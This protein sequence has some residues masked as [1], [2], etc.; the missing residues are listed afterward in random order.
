MLKSWIKAICFTALALAIVPSGALTDSAESRAAKIVDGFSVD[1]V[2][3][4]MTQINI[5][6]LLNS[7]GGLDE[8]KVRQFAKLHVGSYLGSPQ[9]N[10]PIG[11]NYS[12]SVDEWRKMIT[13][14]QDIHKEEG[15]G[16]PIIYGID[17]V[18]GANFILNTTIFGHQINGGASFN[19]DLVRKMGEITG[20]DTAAAGISW[21][22]GPILEL[23]QNPLWPRTYETFGE[24]PYLVS[25]MGSNVIKGIQA[26]KDVAACMKHFVGYSKTPTGHDRDGV[27]LSDFDLLNYFMPPFIAATQA[28]VKSA[29]ENYISINGVPVVA[30][31]K[32]LRDLLRRDLGFEG[33][34]VTD[35]AEIYNLN[36]FHRVAKSLS[37]AVRMSL[38]QTSIDMSMVAMDSNFITYA[39]DMLK[40]FPE[41]YDRL[42]ES[43][44]RI[45]K[46]KI[47]LGLY[48]TPVPGAKY[49]KDVGS[50]AHR[51]VALDLARESIVLLKN[52]DNTLPL[53]TSDTV[54]LTGHSADDRGNLCG[55]WSLRWPGYS[56]NSMF[57]N[58]I[59]VKDGFQKLASISSVSY[60]N[61]LTVNGTYTA[62]DLAKAKEL[63]SKAK[64]TV[65][66]IGEATYAEKSG[67]LDD[68]ALPI[69]Q[70]N[71][72]KELASTGTKVIVVL[73]GGRPRLLSGLPSNVHAVINALLPGELGGQAI[74]EIIYG[75]VNPSGRL[76]IT[77]PK[78]PANIMIPYNRRVTTL[79]ADQTPCKMEWDF[80]TGLSY[81]TFSYS[82]VKLSKT[83][84]SGKNDKVKASVTVTN[85]GKVKGKETVMLFLIQPFR[86]ISVPEAKQLKKFEKIELAPGKSKTV[87]FELNYKDWSVFDPQIGKGF[88][89]SA[90]DGDFVV[91]I[92]PETDCDVYNSAGITNPLCAKFTLESSW[93]PFRL[94]APEQTGISIVSESD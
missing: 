75:K 85:T 50:S 82:A 38:T 2:L 74:A 58:G 42:K 71:Y 49:V 36:S 30:S 20:R 83:K 93:V 43:A 10:G 54:F 18:H 33:F 27:T 39:K 19:P 25:V 8:D 45:I 15:N 32:I 66:V 57:P 13:R 92:K 5:A 47:E 55:G 60:F 77:Y 87:E 62:D 76:P 73:V 61:G 53:S 41:Y 4:Q 1:E 51:D 80:G 72:V 6:V 70:I 84:V 40:D 29:M 89:R 16:H 56:G 91:A 24:D 67:D 9:T 65:A 14:I 88:V 26:N 59:S 68:L 21:T 86:S 94:N 11:G 69:G 90:E 81:T 78:D 64:Y 31:S 79:C 52:Q 37:E 46:T 44:R 48:E 34:V 17:S 3:G 35:F 22:F 23:S 63:A 28:G 12:S 7:Q